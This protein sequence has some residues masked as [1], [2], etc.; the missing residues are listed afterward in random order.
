[1][2]VLEEPTNPPTP[3]QPTLP[4]EANFTQAELVYMD[5][6]P[7][8]L[9]PENQDSNFGYVI[10]KIFSD[11]SQDIANWQDILYNEHFVNTAGRFIDQWEIEMGLPIDPSLTLVARQT[12]VLARIQRGPF[13]RT[14][15]DNVIEQYV[16]ATFGT[17]I[18]L[19]P[20]GVPITSAGIPIYGESSNLTP[21]YEVYE[22]QRNFSYEVW[23]NSAYTPSITA[24][25]RELKRI[26]PAGISFTI[27]N[28]HA[29]ILDYF[30]TMRSMAP[31]AYWRLGN[32]ADS[33]GNGMTLTVSGATAGNVAAPGLLSAAIGGADGATDFTPGQYL[34]GGGA[35]LQTPLSSASLMAWIQPDTVPAAGSNYAGFLTSSGETTY[36][37]LYGGG[38]VLF[39][40]WLNGK[41]Q[42]AVFSPSNT[43]VA[44]S[45]YF[46]VATYDGSI[47]RLYVNGA[48]VGTSPAY[49]GTIMLASGVAIIGLASFGSFDGKVDEAAYF[50]RALSQG[51]ITK[52]YNTGINVNA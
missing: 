18:Q 10:R 46:V 52:L 35:P 14:R 33:S 17:T 2:S 11:V 22:N 26:T 39:S 9:F 43:I 28:S 20:Q 30:R 36:L 6:S 38:A 29:N 21:L 16:K 44:G 50:N 5:E 27:D 3:H 40:A 13:T 12:N 31:I 15:R 37:S 23:I 25:T 34:Q 24:L 47:L 48:L 42:R 51:E 19:V 4:A 8:G 45:K 32:L 41:D 7:P 49:P 1:M